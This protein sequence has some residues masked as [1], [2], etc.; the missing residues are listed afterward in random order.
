RR[1]ASARRSAQPG[2]ARP[3][4]SSVEVVV[5]IGERRPVAL[6][7]ARAV[8]DRVVAIL[9]IIGLVREPRRRRRGKDPVGLMASRVDRIVG[10]VAGAKSQAEVRPK[11]G[12]AI[13]ARWRA[14]PIVTEL[15]ATPLLPPQRSTES[16]VAC[17]FHKYKVDT[18]PRQS[19]RRVLCLLKQK[20]HL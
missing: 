12:A 19:A 5:G 14:S 7:Q 13:E 16:M 1:R 2:S 10:P 15:R 6:A 8:A 9:L 18:Q 11:I 3:S 4:R 20:Y 17:A